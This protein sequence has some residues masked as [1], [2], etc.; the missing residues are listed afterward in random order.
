ML[1]SPNLYSIIIIELHSTFSQ[2]DQDSIFYE[3]NLGERKIIL[4]TNVAE[5]SI[6]I[7]DCIFV[8]DSGKMK[9]K[10]FNPESNL[11]SLDICWISKTNAIQR[12]GRAGRVQSGV[13]I[14]LYSSF[15]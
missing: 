6:T 1:R 9:E 12:R 3:P 14:H 7:P 4:S 5:T 10:R 15:R 13:C 11:E 8:I 2:E